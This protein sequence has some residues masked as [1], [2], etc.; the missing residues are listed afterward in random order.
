MLPSIKVEDKR[1]TRFVIILAIALTT[2]PYFIGLTAAGSEWKF[3]GFLFGVTD[4]NS[5]L[6]KMFR[7]YA[8]EW[9]FRTPYTAVEQGGILAF[10]PYLILGKLTSPPAQHLQLVVL[11]HIF[12]ILGL[13]FV[14]GITERFLERFLRNKMI[15]RWALMMIIFG[16][17]LGWI[18]VL[19]GRLDW[20]EWIPLSFYSPESFGFLA[21]FG[22]P[23]L[24]FSRGLL[25]LGLLKIMEGRG[26]RSGAETGIFWLLMAL[27]Q[28]LNMAVAWLVTGG[29]G[30][31]LL[32]LEWLPVRKPFEAQK[33]STKKQLL[34]ILWALGITLPV[35]V[36]YGLI[37]QTGTFSSWQA[38]SRVLS[39][40]LVE[41]LLA[42]GL[43][44]PF[45]AAFFVGKNPRKFSR[46]EWM[47]II[48]MGMLPLLINI[49][50][51]SQRRLAEGSWAALVT[52]GALALDSPDGP[53]RL[54]WRWVWLLTF[55]TALILLAGG[56]ASAVNPVRPVFLPENEVEAYL[57]LK[58]QTSKTDVVLSSFKT[59]NVLPAWAPVYVV[60]GHPA[61]TLD[62]QETSKRV[63]DFYQGR[64]DHGEM[65]RMLEEFSVDFVFWGPSE[66]ELAEEFVIEHPCLKKTYG[67]RYQIFRVNCDSSDQDHGVM[68]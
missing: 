28:P 51:N 23:H 48:W 18:P 34:S 59:G 41:Y 63:H 57:Y 36:Y 22:I 61:E 24:T 53:L 10:L 4:G 11:Y 25:F 17:G 16:G 44:L 52:L 68:R 26:A 37:Y 49:P 15:K 38:Q 19:V 42:Y 55:P 12:R 3:S 56:T 35:M 1:W 29:Y 66:R 5:Y 9:L 7:G 30:V 64:L 58:D 47:L 13:I 67:D 50:I 60:L 31:S 43:I 20:L 39:P 65:T 27:F 62:Y 33:F 46:R 54:S 40:G 6:A 21:G 8:G 45:A 2:L 32:L 14:I